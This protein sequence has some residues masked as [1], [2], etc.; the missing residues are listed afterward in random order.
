MYQK[1]A[2]AASVTRCVLHFT[3]R[4]RLFALTQQQED[5]R[6]S[7]YLTHGNVISWLCE[8]WGVV[9]SIA[10]NNAHFM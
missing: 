3:G 7:L 1:R 5:G 10:D 2:G 4:H 9:I 6:N 8:M